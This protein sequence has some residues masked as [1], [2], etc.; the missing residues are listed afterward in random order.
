MNLREQGG[1]AFPEPHDDHGGGSKGMTLRDWFA[2]QALMSAAFDDE[3][4]AS[5]AASRAYEYADAMI[6]ARS[7]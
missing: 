7:N 3:I 2:G 4:E 5:D 1:F 6:A